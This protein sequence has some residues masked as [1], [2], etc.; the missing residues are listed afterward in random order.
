MLEFNLRRRYQFESGQ[1]SNWGVGLNPVSEKV[2]SLNL[3]YIQTGGRVFEF[4]LRKGAQ[5]ESGPD[6]N[7]GGRVESSFREGTQFES[8]PDLNNGGSVDKA[9]CC[10]TS[11]SL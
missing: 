4:S 2:P 1:D 3:V 6:L 11:Q 8:G 9:H 7:E 10:D 5:F